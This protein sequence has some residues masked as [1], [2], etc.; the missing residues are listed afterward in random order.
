MWA[1]PVGV[2]CDGFCP[3]LAVVVGVVGEVDICGVLGPALAVIVVGVLG[4]LPSFWQEA[5]IVSAAIAAG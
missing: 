4:G 1:V 3:A 2:V 5:V